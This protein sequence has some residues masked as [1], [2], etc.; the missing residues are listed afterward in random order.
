MFF[1]RF[2][3]SLSYYKICVVTRANYQTIR[4]SIYVLEPKQLVRKY[5]SKNDFLDWTLFIASF[6]KYCIIVVLKQV[7][8]MLVRDK[9]TKIRLFLAITSVKR[10]YKKCIVYIIRN[11][12]VERN[13]SCDYDFRS[14]FTGVAKQKSCHS[15]FTAKHRINKFYDKE[16]S[17]WQRYIGS[18]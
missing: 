8:N 7:K 15:Y 11:L 2:Y 6:F 14:L 4:N 13:M 12:K 1:F 18:V 3:I 5:R 17:L 10:K 16:R 9:R